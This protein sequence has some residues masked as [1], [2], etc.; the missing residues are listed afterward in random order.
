[1]QTSK[2][3]FSLLC[4]SA[5][6]AS[7]HAQ[8]SAYQSTL[9]NF[10]VSTSSGVQVSFSSYAGISSPYLSGIASASYNQYGSYSGHGG[11]AYADNAVQAGPGMGNAQSGNEFVE[12]L[13]FTDTGGTG[14]FSI[15]NTAHQVLDTDSGG[16]DASAVSVT[17]E[18]GSYFYG[19][20]STY[21]QSYY[22]PYSYTSNW[23]ISTVYHNGYDSIT[24]S[25]GAFGDAV[26]QGSPITV[27][28]RVFSFAQ[29]SSKGTSSV[30]GPEA[31]AP[32]A[33]GLLGALRRRR[34]S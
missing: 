22:P 4:L 13:T 15:Y 30:P 23:R 1:M 28:I 21:Q 8:R 7:A 25:H 32:F 18:G 10:T 6:A 29:V 31:V 17:E 12:F 26:Y 3:A 16:F 5:V 9:D 33:V 34:K 11:Y 20:I 24:Q 14:H 27:E 2:T 19:S